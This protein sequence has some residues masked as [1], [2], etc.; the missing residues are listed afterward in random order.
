LARVFV[1][2]AIKLTGEGQF[3]LIH[4]AAKRAREI[5]NGSTPLVQSDSK[6]PTVLALQEIEEGLYTRDHFEGNIKSK[7]EL[8]KEKQETETLNEY[9]ST[10]GK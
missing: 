1:E 7:E 4:M 2:K 6:A 9:Q 5:Q 3:D 10:E 8:A